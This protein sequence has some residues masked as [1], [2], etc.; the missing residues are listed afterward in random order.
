MIFINPD[1]GL[2]KEGDE[3]DQRKVF[4][5]AKGGGQAEETFQLLFPFAPPGIGHLV[6]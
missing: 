2:N 4:E 1:E 3:I 5:K 6:F